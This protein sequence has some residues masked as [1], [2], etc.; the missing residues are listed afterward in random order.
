MQAVLEAAV[1]RYDEERFWGRV[2]AAFARPEVQQETAETAHELES[3]HNHEPGS[4]ET[5]P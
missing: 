2:E 5:W 1:L 3:M 4:E